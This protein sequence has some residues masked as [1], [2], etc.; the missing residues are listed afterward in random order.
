MKCGATVCVLQSVALPQR[1]KRA[2]RP[3]LLKTQT[4]RV[5][6]TTAGP[7]S[8]FSR[9]WQSRHDSDISG[10]S[11]NVMS[12]CDGS[13]LHP[14][15]EAGRCNLAGADAELLQICQTQVTLVHLQ[16]KSITSLRD[17]SPLFKVMTWASKTIYC[18]LL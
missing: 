10:G 17:G 18:P 4:E 8:V 7:W 5:S 15:Q 3:L 16:L 9:L 14:A 2:A 11:L 13:I 1:G 12:G 6:L